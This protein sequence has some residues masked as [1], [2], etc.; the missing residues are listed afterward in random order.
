MTQLIDPIRLRLTLALTGASAGGVFWVL[1]E[2]L[3][4]LV[5]NQRA[6]LFIAA[7][8]GSLFSSL[9]LLVGRLGLR[10][11]LRYALVLALVS[12][13]LLLWAS[14]RFGKVEQFLEAI[15][16]FLAFFYLIS[17]PLPFFLAQ[18]TAPGGWRDYDALFDHAWSIFVRSGTAW[19]FTGLFWL[20]LLLSD[21][22]LSLVGFPY[23]GDLTGKLW[24][25][26][27]LTG[28]VLG[29][30]LAVLYELKTVVSTLRR[31]AL[32]LLRL[33]LPLVA[34]VVALFILLVPFRG[35]DAVF[36]SLSAAGTMLAMA[37]GAVTLITSATDARDEDAV[38]SRLM[39]LSVR[40][41]SLL[42]PVIAAIAVYAIWE[43][44]GQY[45]W[46]PTR[47]SATVIA[48]LVLAYALAYAGAVLSRQNWRARIRVANTALALAVIGLSLL[49]MTPMFNL[50]K[51][52]AISQVDRFLS[53]KIGVKELDVWQL[54]K[55]W[56]KSGTA[57]LARI[58]EVR[59]HPEQA[60][61]DDKLAR[62]DAGKSRW[63]VDANSEEQG[64]AE[65]LASL[66]EGLPVRPKGQEIPDG[67]LEALPRRMLS[68][69]RA[70]CDETLPDGRPECVLVLGEFYAGDLAVSGVVFWRMKN[71][72]EPEVVSF[73][74][75]AGD[76]EYSYRRDVLFLGGNIKTRDATALI[77]RLL[78]GGYSFAPA[79]LRALEIDGIQVIPRR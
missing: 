54:G 51:I 69:L 53:G 37:I 43:R 60:A 70:S 14:F 55:R 62:F 47:L 17:L 39:V 71:A 15:H 20:V 50:E 1:F 30:A 26:M 64:Y 66:R 44:V 4:D 33:L 73:L 27:P 52:S 8:A 63:V 22:L 57:A 68:E 56:G 5:D 46:T 19:A 7:F 24:I 74:R 77:T 61:L 2:Y 59:D 34:L 16:P 72:T 45:G 79:R 32:Q 23:L 42:L 38:R 67:M 35:L 10:A 28:V 29:L 21:Q 9:L 18:E 3:P 25:A 40:L 6:L 41:L 31:L 48:V 11:A 58:R 49:W 65:N 36:G 13:L 76:D 78:D 75:E 12:A